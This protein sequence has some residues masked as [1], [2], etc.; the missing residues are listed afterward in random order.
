MKPPASILA[1][2]SGRS[3]RG[4]MFMPGTSCRTMP[5]PRSSAPARACSR[6]S[7]AWASRTSASPR[8][9][10]WKTASTPCAWSCRNAGSTRRNARAGS[11]RSSFIAPNTTTSSRRCGRSRCT[12]GEDREANEDQERNHLLHGLELRRRVDRAAPA[13]SRHRHAILDEGDRPARHDHPHE[14]D[15]LE[16]QVSVLGERYE[17]V[18][19]EEQQDRPRVG[20]EKR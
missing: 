16:A 10:G 7:K 19:T 2:T 4:L 8:Y 18:G 17:Q 5:R 3:A 14:R 9:I 20:R 11:T 13:I 1:T 15:L 12:T 6:Y